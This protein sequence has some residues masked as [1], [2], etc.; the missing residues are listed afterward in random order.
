MPAPATTGFRRQAG[1]IWRLTE[2]SGVHEVVVVFVSFLIYF[3]IRG[4]VV[5]RAGE[6]MVRGFN[7]IELEQRLGIYWEL[8]MQSWILDHYWL[9]KTMNAIYF[10][11]HMPLVIVLAVWLYIWH[12]RAYRLTRNAFLASGAIGVVIYWLL[13][14]APPRL[15]PF[16]GFIDTMAAFD[17][18]GYNAQEAKAWVNPF[19]AVPSLHFGWSLLLAAVVAWVGRRPA[20]WV[21]AVLWPIAMFFAVIVTGNHFILDAVFGAVVSFAGLG[22]AFALERWWRP[23]WQALTAR[24]LALEAVE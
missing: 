17:R 2:R 8:E 5:D 1:R 24:L 16:A 11:G 20:L 3:L 22:V 12:R 6:A 21:F 14:V 23:T 19:A 10:W 7:L 9:I 4:S 15:I 13:P 18:V